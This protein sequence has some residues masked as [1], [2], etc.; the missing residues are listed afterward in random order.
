VGTSHGQWGEFGNNTCGVD[1]AAQIQGALFVNKPNL[2]FRGVG[3]SSIVQLASNAKMRILA[4]V[5]PG[6]LVEKLVFDGNGAQRVRLD[7]NGNPYSWP[8]GLVVDGLLAGTTSEGTTTI[9]DVEARNAIEDGM[10]MFQSPNF[11]VKGVYVHDNGGYG[12]NPAFRTQA[13]AA[14]I[15]LSGGT[16]QTATDNIVVGNTTG[17]VAAFGAVGVTIADNVILHQCEAGLVLGTGPDP[18]PPPQPD[19]QFAVSRNWVEG[20]GQDCVFGQ[21]TVISGQHGLFANN[22]ILNSPYPGVVIDDLGSPWPASIDWQFFGNTIANNHQNGI[23][24][25]GRSQNII[26]KT[27]TFANNGQTPDAQVVID[28]SAAGSVNS[29]W[30]TT[31]TFTYGSNPPGVPVITSA[32]ISNAASG[33][34]NDLSPGELIWISGSGLGPSGGVSAVPNASGRYDRALA[35]TRV[36]FNGV[37]GAM[38]YTSATRVAVLVPYF[39][40]WRD[41]TPVQVEYNGVGSNAV[42]MNVRA[43]TPGVFTNTSGVGPGAIFNQDNS[44]NSPVNPASRGSVVTVYTTG[45]GQTDP[46]GID[47]LLVDMAS[48]RLPVSATIGGVTA[49]ISSAAAIPG[50]IPGS[51]QIKLTVPPISP[52]GAAVP[53]QVTIGGGTAAPVSLA[54]SPGAAPFTDNVIVPGVTPVRVVHLQELRS[55]IAALRTYH[56]LAPYPYVDPGLAAGAPILA[57]HITDLRAALADVYA[58]VGLTAPTYTDPLLA[59][60]LPIKAAHVTELRAAV[61]AIE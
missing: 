12:V 60:S 59:L 24:V 15:S 18:T 44:P 56:G 1:P 17:I 6:L 47:G 31:N 57:V 10:G 3:R 61:I 49:A 45:V 28:P 21:V 39:L 55:R 58:A 11:L 48:P 8:C 32:G 46:A 30:P 19:A 33:V 9:Q 23:W 41:T 53:L 13:G 5:Q 27:N 43:A 20:N 37:P 38:W 22:T 35:G 29:D 36:L 52:S 25:L 14:A 7:S 26:I 34:G 16:S 4:W 2:T 42:T 50:Q 54:V 40:Y 51:I